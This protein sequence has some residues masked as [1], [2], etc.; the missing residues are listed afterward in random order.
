MVWAEDVHEHRSKVERRRDRLR[1]QGKDVDESNAADLMPVAI[2]V[3][4]IAGVS[5]WINEN[6]KLLRRGF[7]ERIPVISRLF[8]G[9]KARK[10]KNARTAAAEAAERRQRSAQLGRSSS[11]QSSGSASGQNR[12]SRKSSR[13]RSN[14]RR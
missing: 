1:S 2:V 10:P 6:H 4:V 11:A 12:S 3:A 9:R 7:L 13:R 8:G 5:L 14:K